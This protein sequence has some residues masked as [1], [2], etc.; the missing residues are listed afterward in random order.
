VNRIVLIFYFSFN[1][2]CSQNEFSEYNQLILDTDYNLVMTPISGGEFSMGSPIFEKSR[3]ADEGPI[4]KVKVDSFW[5][6]KYETTWDLF[7]LFVSRNLDDLQPNYDK[8]SEV[9]IDVDAISG[10]TTPYVEM[11]FGM[12]LEGYP[13]ISMT[14]LAAKKFSKWL[15]AMTGNFYR[16][17]TEAEWEYACRANSNTSY[18]FGND[19]KELDKYAWYD[20]NSQNKYHKV[21]QKLPNKWGLHDMHGNVSEWTLDAYNPS[22]YSQENNILN[23][24]PYNK[25]IKLYPRVVRGGSWMS[26]DYRL[27][28]ASRQGSSKQWKRQDPQIPRSKWW[29][30]DAQ[31]VGFRVIRPLKTPTIEQQN[32][33]W[34]N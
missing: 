7:N 1:F 34:N 29:H 26:S 30:T 17:P 24:N 25:P 4:R 21:G 13:A 8:K 31:F 18:S 23:N 14:Q 2:L 28:S 11:S 3:L 32:E 5:M 12:G 33:Y 22:F 27:R 20:K 15:S 19:P 9:N 6:A 16:L 10:A